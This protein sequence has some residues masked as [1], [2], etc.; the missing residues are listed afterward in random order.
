MELLCEIGKEI[1]AAPDLKKREASRAVLFD[2]NNMIPLLFVSKHNYYKLPGGG[3]NRGEDKIKA[4]EREV[5][6]EVGSKIKVTGEVGKIIEFR[7]KWNLKQTSYCYLGKIVSKGKPNFTKKESEQ[8]FKVV[9]MSLD[10]AI[11][12]IASDEPENYEDS[13]I[14]KRDIAFLEKARRMLDTEP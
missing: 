5:M 14:R 9:W 12:K 4:L 3:I 2:E 1:P 11:S 7:P 13:L 8:G 6:E 10:D